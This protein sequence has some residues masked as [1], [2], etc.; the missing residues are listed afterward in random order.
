[1]CAVASGAVVDLDN[2]D[3]KSYD[4]TPPVKHRH[5]RQESK[6]ERKV[7]LEGFGASLKN[8]ELARVEVKKKRLLF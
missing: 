5:L 7:G 8:E 1:M 4:K 6:S 2:D 3:E